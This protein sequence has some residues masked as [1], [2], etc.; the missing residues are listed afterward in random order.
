MIELERSEAMTTEHVKKG[1]EVPEEYV[2]REESPDRQSEA[3]IDKPHNRDDPE[4]YS[5]RVVNAPTR[6]EE[7]GGTHPS[8]S[9]SRELTDHQPGG[10]KP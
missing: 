3:P 1:T 6:V 7:K 10:A 9:Q 5:K 2:E 8:G 4:V